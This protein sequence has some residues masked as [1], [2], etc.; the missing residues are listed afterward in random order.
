MTIDTGLPAKP[1]E[2]SVTVT[3]RKPRK[4]KAVL[5][6]VNS[7]IVKTQILSSL[8]IKVQKGGKRTG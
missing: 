3:R 2:K 1:E 5:R 6:K 7:S 8:D 4:S